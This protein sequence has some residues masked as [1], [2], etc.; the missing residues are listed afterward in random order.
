MFTLNPPHAR[1]IPRV[2]IFARRLE[3][4]RTRPLG[5]MHTTL[6]AF[7]AGMGVGAGALTLALAPTDP[8]PASKPAATGPGGRA[9]DLYAQGKALVEEG[10]FEDAVKVFAQAN[11]RQANDPD[12]LNMYGFT[13]RKTGKVREAWEMYDRALRLRSDFPEAREYIH[14]AYLMMAREQLEIVRAGGPDAAK[15][16]ETMRASWA[17]HAA[18]VAGMK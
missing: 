7:L 15:H 9:A 6:M 18:E 5:A 17:K 16:L 8:P 2:A 4:R 3:M 10:K 1:Y 14:E 11:R 12:I 13:L